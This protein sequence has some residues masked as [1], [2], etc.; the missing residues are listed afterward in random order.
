[1]EMNDLT[2]LVLDTCIKIHTAIGPG[3]YEKVY[4]ET[5]CYKLVKRNIRVERQILLP[6]IYETLLI[7]DAYRIDLF[8]KRG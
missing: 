1:M 4:G 7:E 5:L 8:W 2:G 6:L 3:R